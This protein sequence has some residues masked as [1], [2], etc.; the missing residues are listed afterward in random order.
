MKQRL[1]HV[2]CLVHKLIMKICSNSL[3]I[4]IRNKVV[5]NVEFPNPII[6]NVQDKGNWFYRVDID[7]HPDFKEDINI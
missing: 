3:V 2:S 7:V 6:T 4:M 5:Q 1:G